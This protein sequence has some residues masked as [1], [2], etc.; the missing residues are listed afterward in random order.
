MRAHVQKKMFLSSPTLLP[1]DALVGPRVKARTILWSFERKVSKNKERVKGLCPAVTIKKNEERILKKTP[2][3]S[4]WASYDALCC[5]AWFDK[6]PVHMR[7]C[8]YLP[9][10]GG[11]T[12]VEHW[13]PAKKGEEG[14]PGKIRKSINYPPIVFFL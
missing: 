13:Y 9:D 11:N 8:Q 7:S 3:I 10:D 1:I 4:C 12:T 5:L 14:F 2:G 6:R